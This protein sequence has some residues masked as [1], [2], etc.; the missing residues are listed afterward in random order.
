MKKLRLRNIE[1]IQY[2]LM[3]LSIIITRVIVSVILN[4]CVK[5]SSEPGPGETWQ[6]VESDRGVKEPRYSI[7]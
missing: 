3:N 6:G 7:G 5:P 4:V 2:L 1:S